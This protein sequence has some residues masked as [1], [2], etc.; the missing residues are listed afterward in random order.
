MPL[1]VQQLGIKSGPAIVLWSAALVAS[2]LT[3]LAASGPCG[4][5]LNVTSIY[6]LP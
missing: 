6:E 1:Y 5:V 3:G 2:G 4:H